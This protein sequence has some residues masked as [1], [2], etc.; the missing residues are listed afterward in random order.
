MRLERDESMVMAIGD[1]A[2]RAMDWGERARLS[3]FDPINYGPSFAMTLGHV[4]RGEYEAAADAAS[5]YFQANPN[6]SFA[7]MFLVATHAALGRSDAAG[8][9]AE[10]VLQLEPGH[11]ISKMCAALDLHASIATPLAAALREAGLPE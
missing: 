5:K 7:H 4:Q 1:E 10:H 11:T 3:P 9:A 6:F 2:D 8:S